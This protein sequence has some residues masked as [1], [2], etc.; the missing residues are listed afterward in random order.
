MRKK[1]K[2]RS[3]F[4]RGALMEQTSRLLILP[5]LSSLRETKEHC[6]MRDD[7]DE[8]W[9]NARWRPIPGLRNVLAAGTFTRRKGGGEN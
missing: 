1:N 6:E 3:P 9:A 5:Y 8:G 2:E 7:P 4:E